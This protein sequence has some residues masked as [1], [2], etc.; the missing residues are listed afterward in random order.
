MI[1][2]KQNSNTDQSRSR[3]VF[4]FLFFL[5]ITVRFLFFFFSLLFFLPIIAL[6]I[7]FLSC[8]YSLYFCYRSLVLCNKD[9]SV[10]FSNENSWLFHYLF[11]IWDIVAVNWTYI[12]IIWSAENSKSSFV[13]NSLQMITRDEDLCWSCFITNKNE[14]KK[15]EWILIIF[16]EMFLSFIDKHICICFKYKSM[17]NIR[18][19][20]ITKIKWFLINLPRFSFEITQLSVLMSILYW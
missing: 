20:Y 10:F 2:N 13:L 14:K 17:I 3:V 6:F 16:E 11:G 18:I 1:F 5:I 12:I 15:G 8:V 19:M 4:V 7:L 9:Y